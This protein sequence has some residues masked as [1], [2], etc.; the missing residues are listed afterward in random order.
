MSDV[1]G[2]GD[3]NDVDDV[4]GTTRLRSGLA[5][6]PYPIGFRAAR[7]V[8][9]RNVR[10][11][12]HSLRAVLSG[13]FEPVFYLFSLGVGIGALVGGI[14]FDGHTVSYQE[15]VAPGLLAASAMNGAVMDS[16]FGVFWK[17]KYARLYDSVLA[18]PLDARAIA[19]G[20]V[21]WALLRGAAYAATF[22][23]VLLVS[24]YISSWWAVLA[25]PAAILIGLAFAGAGMAA[26]TFMRSWQDFD[27]VQLVTLP[28]FLFSATFYPLSTYPHALRIVVELTPLY[29]AVALE[30]Q[31]LLGAVNASTL[32]H[33]VYLVALGVTGMLIAGRR[34][35]RLLLS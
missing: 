24:G 3:R 32:V 7:L 18:T 15:F 35:E 13:F 2:L 27:L 4:G 29:H 11:S 5:A 19:V 17:L 22:I 31:L 26:T 14:R 33:I 34:L 6:L 30:R 8:V 12:R 20:E 16:T 23:V 25:L 1:T 9:E 28:M 10:A 21:T